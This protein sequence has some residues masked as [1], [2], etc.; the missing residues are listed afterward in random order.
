MAI[1]TLAEIQNSPFLGQQDTST[2]D[3]L[4]EADFLNLLVTQLQN[5]DPLNPMESAEFSAQL[6]QFSSLEELIEINENLLFMSDSNIA[7]AQLNALS[8]IGKEVTFQDTVFLVQDG[9]AGQ[10][11]FDLAEDAE[12]VVVRIY[13]P[14]GAEV[15]AVSLGELEAGTQTYQWDAEDNVGLNAEDGAYTYEVEAFDADGQAVNVT[16]RTSFL[17][18][19][20]EFFEGQTLLKVNGEL[21][22]LSS[23]VSVSEPASLLNSNNNGNADS[24]SN[25]EESADE[26]NPLLR[27]F[28]K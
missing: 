8:L 17:V 27:L 3:E 6:A 5:Q 9:Q 4:N 26:V 7:N 23:I 10:V 18:E 13:D 16:A 2:G 24:G 28:S 1:S 12:R 15:D 25:T 11:E 21:V 22:P 20:V 19:G 14:S